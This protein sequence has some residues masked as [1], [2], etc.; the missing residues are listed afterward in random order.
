MDWN[1]RAGS[2]NTSCWILSKSTRSHCLRP[3]SKLFYPK[4]AEWHRPFI[5]NRSFISLRQ[6]VVVGSGDEVPRGVIRLR[7][8]PVIVPEGLNPPLATDEQRAIR[9]FKRPDF[10]WA[11]HDPDGDEPARQFVV[12]CKRLATASSAWVY[13]EQ[14]VIAGVKRFAT[15]NHSYGKQAWAGAM[16]GYVQRITPDLARSEVDA[17]L[18]TAGLPALGQALPSGPSR[19]QLQPRTQQTICPHSVSTATSLAPTDR[20]MSSESRAGSVLRE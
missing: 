17:Y 9:E 10:Y 18:D 12:E 5:R 16:V 20:C 1:R 6:D 7:S 3:W 13:P 11:Y 8:L 14:Y 15:T 19:E 4:V 2:D